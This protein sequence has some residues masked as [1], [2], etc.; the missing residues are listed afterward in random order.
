MACP[1]LIHQVFFVFDSPTIPDEWIQNHAKWKR[2]H[3]D[4][5]V[6][7][8]SMEMVLKLIKEVKPDF[9]EIF[10]RYPHHIQRVDAIRPF[11]LYKYGGVYVDLDTSPRLEITPMLDAYFRAGRT[12]LLAKSLQFKG[13][14]SNWFMASTAKNAFWLHTITM[15]VERSTRFYAFKHYRV[16]KA[17]GPLL[18]TDAVRSF[19]SARISFVSNAL[20]NDTTGCQKCTNSGFTY[21]NDEHASS[22]HSTDSKLLHEFMCRTIFLQ[23]IQWYTWLIAIIVVVIAFI[24]LAIRRRRICS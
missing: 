8:W 7:L 3:P 24:L 6:V 14:V 13:I 19:D 15:M 1:K 2:L 16:M 10:K 12:V 4:Y 11:I 5:K 18:I 22:W 21:V 17:T 23:N 9:V 20:L